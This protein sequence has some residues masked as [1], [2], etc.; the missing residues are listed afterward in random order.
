M[1]QYLINTILYLLKYK[2]Q[3]LKYK[4]LKINKNEKLKICQTSK[5]HNFVYKI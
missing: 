4:Y 5:F 3:L 1:L 2:I